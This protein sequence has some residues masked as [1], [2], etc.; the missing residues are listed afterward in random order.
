MVFLLVL[1]EGHRAGCPGTVTLVLRQV[2]GAADAALRAGHGQGLRPRATVGDAQDLVDLLQT[3][4]GRQ[5]AVDVIRRAG[6][7]GEQLAELVLPGHLRL[8][9]KEKCTEL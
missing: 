6:D 9:E 3:E 2:P 1:V 7:G 8:E 4:V 5:Q